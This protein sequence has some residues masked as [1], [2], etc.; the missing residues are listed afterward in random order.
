MNLLDN[1][2]DALGNKG[3]IIIST[4]QEDGN[5]VVEIP[6]NGSGIPQEIQ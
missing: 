4:R 2:I 6:D 3:A 5:I 1:S